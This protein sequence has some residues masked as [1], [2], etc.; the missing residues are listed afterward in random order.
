VNLV[1]DIRM[2]DKV[3]YSVVV[4]LSIGGFNTSCHISFQISIPYFG[5]AVAKT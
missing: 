1:V 4:L 2:N 5:N 3:S